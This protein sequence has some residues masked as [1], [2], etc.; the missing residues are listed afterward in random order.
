MYIQCYA[1]LPH[2][3]IPESIRTARDDACDIHKTFSFDTN[4]VD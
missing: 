2:V 3:E 1:T 4:M